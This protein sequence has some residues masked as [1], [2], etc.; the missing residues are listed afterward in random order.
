MA[1]QEI[2]QVQEMLTVSSSQEQQE[3]AEEEEGSDFKEQAV[4]GWIIR[5]RK[6]LYLFNT[7][8]FFSLLSGRFIIQNIQVF[9]K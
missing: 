3:A 4:V 9:K 1:R 5:M 2:G 8:S 7:F 6:C